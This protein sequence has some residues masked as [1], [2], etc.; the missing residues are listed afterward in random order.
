MAHPDG[1]QRKVS[2]AFDQ[3]H[4]LGRHLHKTDKNFPIGKFVDRILSLCK[5]VAI[6]LRAHL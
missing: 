3:R 1:I 4:R 5:P 2:T 6:S